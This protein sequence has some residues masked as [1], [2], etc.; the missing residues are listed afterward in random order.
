MPPL[1][2]GDYWQMHDRKCVRPVKLEVAILALN[3]V[4]EFQYEG[5][6]HGPYLPLAGGSKTSIVLNL[7]DLLYSPLMSFNQKDLDHVISLAHLNVDPS[8]KPLYLDQIQRILGHMEDLERFDLST[9]PPSMGTL[10]GPTPLRHDSV[11][12]RTDL[13]LE[14]NAPE[15]EGDSFVVPK[16]LTD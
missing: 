4:P 9:V 8:L 6:G 2:G 5:C 1:L 3:R 15:W 13:H 10:D 12:Q 7:R 14:S 11:V 16:I